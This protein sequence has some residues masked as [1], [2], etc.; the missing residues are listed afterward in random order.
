M[1]VQREPPLLPEDGDAATAVSRHAQG[2]WTEDERLDV[3]PRTEDAV[4]D[5]HIE[6]GR[7]LVEDNVWRHAEGCVAPNEEA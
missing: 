1:Q 5:L 6:C 4:E 3:P 7:A 2:I